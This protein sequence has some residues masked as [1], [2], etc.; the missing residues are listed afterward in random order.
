MGY[1][2]NKSDVYL[3]VLFYIIGI[4]VT[5]NGYDY[6]KGLKE[7]IFDTLIYIFFSFIVA[8][9]IVFKL[10]PYFFPRKQLV[11]LFILTALFMSIAGVIETYLY[12]W[13]EDGSG[14]KYFQAL[15]KSTKYWFWGISSSSEN[16]GILIGVLLGKKFYDAQVDIQKREKEKKE[17]ELRLL[18]SQI[19]PHF[20]FN[21]LNTVDFLI[22]TDPKVA[23]EY[24]QKLSQL[25]RYLIRTKDD[26]VV[27][28]ED[29]ME[30]ARNYIY[31][32]EKRFGKAYQFVIHDEQ[33]VQEQFILPG[34]LQTVI[35]NVV[36]HNMSTT[37]NPIVTDLIITRD[38][39]VVSNDLRLKPNVKTS[40][41]TGLEN[42]KSRYAWLSEQEI[43]ITTDEKFSVI[44][45]LI[46]QID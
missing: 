26:E 2:I 39:V 23:K 6:S 13:V 14:T 45:P 9:V 15:F 27:L 12:V 32:I 36:K 38:E 11:L 19:D 30:F 44:L 33:N 41:K 4:A 22:D 29:E 28:L 40:N 24:L 3:I 20:L 16:A 5:L 7:P 25:Y 31:L 43:V 10:F 34:A 18:K 46:N 21:N 42:L 8:Y 37:E 17:N 1:K 35:E